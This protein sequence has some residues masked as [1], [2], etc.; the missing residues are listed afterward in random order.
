M[1]FDKATSNKETQT[2]DDNNPQ[3][4]HRHNDGPKPPSGRP[5]GLVETGDVIE[6]NVPERKLNL[7]VSEEVLAE[8]RTKWKPEEPHSQRGWVKIYVDHVQ[9]ANLGADLDFLVGGSGH[10]IPRHSH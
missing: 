4:R 7:L 2:Y 6:L 8:R 5:L 9:Q 10:G 3:L 1:S